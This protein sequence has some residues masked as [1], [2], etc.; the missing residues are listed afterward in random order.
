MSDA[1]AAVEYLSTPR[2]IRDRANE[3]L[4]LGIAGKL[5]FDL[6]LAHLGDVTRRVVKTTRAAYPDLRIPPHG[7]LRHFLAGGIDRVRALDGLD[8]EERLR[9]LADLIVTSVLLDAGAGA[10]WTYRE[11]GRTFSRSEGLAV[12][13]FHAFAAGAFSSDPAR[14]WRADRAGLAS[15]DAAALAKAFQVGPDN[16]LEGLEG[17]A[18]LIRRLGDALAAR[19]DLFGEREPRIGQLA[20]VLV[21]RAGG[22][23]EASSILAHVLDAFRSIWPSRHEID[24]VPLGDVWPHPLAGG[25][26]RAKGLVPFHK[27]SQWLTY[28]LLEPIEEAGVRVVDLDELTG[29]AEY[30]NGGLFVDAG[31]LTLARRTSPEPF[32]ASAPEIVEWRALTLALLDRVAAD[33]RREL[34]VDLALAQILEGGTW[35]AGREIAR[36]RRASGAPPI[37]IASDGTVF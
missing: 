34:G 28:S 5:H 20:V 3:L 36:E 15:F 24:G 8:R 11:D 16:P 35:A 10:R 13:S 26:G 6:D 19:P 2:A 32:A 25:A 23:V 7:R 14:P 27:L 29:L 17:R 12:A 31:V 37:A 4:E 22:T 18:A 30:R 21:E 9:T 33:V 1:R